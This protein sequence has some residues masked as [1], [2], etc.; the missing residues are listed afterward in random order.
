MCEQMEIS[1]EVNPNNV[2][3][4]RGKELQMNMLYYEMIDGND[5]FVEV[6]KAYEAEV[7]SGRVDERSEL[8]LKPRPTFSSE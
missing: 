3:N 2:L 6:L 8:I 5:K 7:D 1:S 4:S